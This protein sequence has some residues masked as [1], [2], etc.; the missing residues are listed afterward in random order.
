VLVLACLALA[1]LL[2]PAEAALPGRDLERL[3]SSPKIS[4]ALVATLERAG[5]AYVSI[6]FS[7]P[8]REDPAYAGHPA[9]G[10]DVNPL[11]FDLA[12]MAAST[13]V[14]L[15]GVGDVQTFTGPMSAN[16]LLT[17][18]DNPHVLSIGSARRPKPRT[19]GEQVLKAACAPSSTT[20]CLQG[21][22]FSVSVTH[23]GNTSQVVSSTSDSAV[24]WTFWSTTYEILVK[25]GDGCA[26]NGR[27]WVFAAGATSTSY[28]ATV[29]DHVRG[30]VVRYPNASCPLIDTDTFTC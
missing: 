29:Q 18:L 19:S 20:A 28:D 7:L 8:S 6:T 26:L 21:G 30:L 9:W 11:V 17:L 4:P 25:V 2:A 13:D 14:H 5:K 10:T 3:S 23:G 22:R 16:A 12:S 1:G 15:E 27:Y 24:F